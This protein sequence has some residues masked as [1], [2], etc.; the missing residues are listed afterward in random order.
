MFAMLIC[1]NNNLVHKS[2]L[3]HSARLTLSYSFSG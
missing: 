3:N 2:M 1:V